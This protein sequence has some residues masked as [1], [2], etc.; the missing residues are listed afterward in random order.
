M[1]AVDPE[2]RCFKQTVGD[3][4]RPESIGRG[5]AQSGD[6]NVRDEFPLLLLDPGVGERRLDLL[7]ELKQR[8]RFFDSYPERFGSATW[9]K[10]PD[11][12]EVELERVH[13]NSVQGS[14]D[15]GKNATIDLTD[16]SKC[17]MKLLRVEPSRARQAAADPDQLVRDIRG[18]VNSD[19]QA[20]HSSLYVSDCR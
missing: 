11:P 14:S 3:Y 12:F 4:I 8:V 10:E 7:V 13:I 18:Q 2:R 19:K 6:R 9:R 5:G 1:K 20:I 17:Q 15:V 16:K